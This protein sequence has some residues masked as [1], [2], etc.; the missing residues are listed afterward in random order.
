MPSVKTVGT[1]V[2]LAL[3]TCQL[4][5]PQRPLPCDCTGASWDLAGVG[6]KG[7]RTSVGALLCMQTPSTWQCASFSEFLHSRRALGSL[8]HPQRI[9]HHHPCL[10]R[11]RHHPTSPLSVSTINFRK[12]LHVHISLA[13]FLSSGL[14]AGDCMG[15][16][17]RPHACAHPQL[18]RSLS[19]CLSL[20]RSLALSLALSRSLS[21]ARALS[22]SL[23]LSLALSRSLALT[24]SLSL[25]VD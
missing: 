24:L 6:L 5:E 11:A 12:S 10:P 17:P 20:S 4:A 23:A 15:L 19:L 14:W 7:C 18:L 9:R 13:L 16:L 22:R 8:L 25:C 2:H 3:T 1:L 21:L